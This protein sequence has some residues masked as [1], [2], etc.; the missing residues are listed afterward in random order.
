MPYH[1][2]DVQVG[3][4]LRQRRT[5]PGTTQRT[6]G[7]AVELTFQQVQEYKRGT[8]RLGANKL[9]EFAKVLDVPVSY[10]F[11]AMPAE[12]TR[13]KGKNGTPQKGRVKDPLVKRESLTPSDSDCRPLET[14]TAIFGG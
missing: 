7:K 10:F 11:N 3:A 5:L 13:F 8:N 2:I 9:Y 4:R 14:R 1:P 12:A 6:L